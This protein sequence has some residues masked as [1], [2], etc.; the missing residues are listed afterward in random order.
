M[1]FGISS[2]SQSTKPMTMK[3]TLPRNFWKWLGAFMSLAAIFLI[4]RSAPTWLNLIADGI[5]DA[6]PDCKQNVQGE[7][8]K[9]AHSRLGVAGDIF[10]SVSALF[11]GL[12]LFAVAVTLWLDA[13]ARQRAKKPLVV[14]AFNED[15]LVLDRASIEAPKSMRLNVSAVAHNSGEVA[16]NC[17]IK[18]T[19]AVGEQ[20]FGLPDFAVAEPL[21]T[22]GRSELKITQLI[23]GQQLEL[24]L[25]A[26]RTEQPIFLITDV[27][28]ESLEGVRWSTIVKHRIRCLQEIGRS[29]LLA[30]EHST[31]NFTDQWAGGAA[32]NLSM[33]VQPGSWSYKSV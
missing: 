23:Q 13:S 19:I 1:I 26:I 24:L 31:N 9:W 6:S 18:S 7:S 10:G 8:C 21:A 33:T 27:E 25:A 22:G 11:S 29:R 30:L 12:G 20:L 14:C 32:V 15:S 16:L 17:E 2:R 28:C 3:I 5:A 4:W